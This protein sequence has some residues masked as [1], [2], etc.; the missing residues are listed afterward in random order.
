M[1]CIYTQQF[2]VL[3]MLPTYLLYLLYL[4][5]AKEQSKEKKNSCPLRYV[6]VACNT[7]QHNTTQNATATGAWSKDAA[8]QPELTIGSSRGKARQLQARS[9]PAFLSVS[10]G[11]WWRDGEG[12][13]GPNMMCCLPTLYVC[14]YVCIDAA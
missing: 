1:I 3:C 10:S 7:T 12:G 13:G 9:N 14:M 8:N 5:M 4:I 2:V 11:L 6:R